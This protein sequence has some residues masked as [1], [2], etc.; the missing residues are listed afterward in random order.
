MS[1]SIEQ[2]LPWV[3]VK[4]LVPV[5]RELIELIGIVDALT[6][7]ER[8]GGVPLWVTVSAD[9]AD[10]LKAILPWEAVV[11]LCAAKGGRWLNLPKADRV[12]RQV[13]DYYL[14]LDRQ[15]M[16]AAETALKYRLTRRQVI[17][18]CNYEDY[19]VID[20]PVDDRQVDLFRES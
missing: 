11:V 6:L 19:K 1:S 5:A 20:K 14:R 17:N 9:K 13:R 4:L 8:R 15:V 12:V 16:T 3:N 2:D 7:L 10:A 18:I